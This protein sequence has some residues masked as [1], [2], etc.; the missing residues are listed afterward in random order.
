MSVPFIPAGSVWKV[1]CCYDYDGRFCF[2]KLHVSNKVLFESAQ[3]MNLS[4]LSKI[5]VP[6][7][8]FVMSEAAELTFVRSSLIGLDFLVQDT[9]FPNNVKGQV[10]VNGMPSIV[11]LVI[12]WRTGSSGRSGMGR[13]FHFAIPEHYGTFKLG[14]ND[15][16]KSHYNALADALV[17]NFGLEGSDNNLQ[18][19]VLS[20]KQFNSTHDTTSSFSPVTHMNV[21]T[22]FTSCSKRRD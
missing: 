4:V 9:Y 20:Q 14:L 12:Q 10:L 3:E 5:L 8:H 7:Y 11:G 16:G 22:R 15:T 1:E 21:H 13:Q 2:H 18:L 6:Y 17:S 19:G